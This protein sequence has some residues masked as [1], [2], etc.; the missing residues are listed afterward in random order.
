V[1]SLA[2]VAQWIHGTAVYDLL[3][4]DERIT[5]RSSAGFNQSPSSNLPTFVSMAW[6]TRN[7]SIASERFG[8]ICQTLF[9][10]LGEPM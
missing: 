9:G 7:Q 3:Q 8:G 10:F 5:K 1:A 6:R 4:L 2:E